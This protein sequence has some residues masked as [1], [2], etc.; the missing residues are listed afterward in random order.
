MK[1]DREHEARQAEIR[2]EWLAARQKDGASDREAFN[3]WR[4][5]FDPSGALSPESMIVVW[6]LRGIMR[7]AAGA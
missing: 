7:A 6:A 1:S 2:Q 4:F 3:A 5:G